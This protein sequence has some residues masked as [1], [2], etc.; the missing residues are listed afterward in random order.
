M[1]KYRI[2]F[3]ILL[4]AMAI[5]YVGGCRRAGT[6]LVKEDVPA[7]ADAMVILM[8]NF[9]D[10]VLQ[11]ADLYHERRS[12]KLIIVEESMGPFRTLEARGANIISN[13]EQAQ[14]AC[15]ALGIPADSITVLPGDARS[16]QDEAIVVRDYMSRCATIDTLLLV[17]SSAHM[18]RASM[19]FRAALCNSG[20]PVFIGCSP[21]AYS[22][23]DAKHWW[24]G[25]EDIQKVLSEFVKMASFVVFEKR[26]LRV[27]VERRTESIEA[28]G[29]KRTFDQTN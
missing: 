7:H 4:L 14:N 16:T 25:K 28:Q 5:L 9:P 22:D 2:I 12:G 10:R 20:P 21:S 13:T 27:S 8:G 3:F 17:S 6:W 29:N 26:D 18:R 11:A 19:I 23:F 1:L 15:I 24:R